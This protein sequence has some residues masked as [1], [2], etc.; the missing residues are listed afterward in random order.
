M[1]GGQAQ[2]DQQGFYLCGRC[3]TKQFY[4]LNNDPNS[5]CDVCGYEGQ[6]RPYT[7]LPS[8]IKLDITQY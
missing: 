3:H 1:S 6:G 8:N 5:V 4:L 2:D 7:T